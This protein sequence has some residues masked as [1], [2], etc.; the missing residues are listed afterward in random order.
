MGNLTGS[1][2]GIIKFLYL[3][4]NITRIIKFTKT[5]IT[6]CCGLTLFPKPFFMNTKSLF[7][8]IVFLTIIFTSLYS[9]AQTDSL[10][11]PL[12]EQLRNALDELNTNEIST[13]ILYEQVPEYFPL[14]FMDG[15]ILPDSLAMNKNSFVLGYG[16][17]YSAHIDQTGILPFR[18]LMTGV[19]NHL[20]P[21]RN[22][23]GFMYYRYNR[24]KDS[25]LQDSTIIV[26]QSRN[27]ILRGPNLLSPYVED[28]ILIF[29][30]MKN[31][32]YEKQ[33]T[34]YVE[35]DFL[36][37]NMNDLFEQAYIDFG[38]GNGF[39]AVR[40][41]S[42]FN[43]VYPSSGR[44]LITFKMLSGS[45]ALFAYS[46]IQIEDEPLRSRGY[47]GVETLTIPNVPQLEVFHWHPECGQAGYL[48][49]LILLDGFDPSD[50]Y[51]LDAIQEILD[52][53]LGSDLYPYDYD[54]FFINNPKNSYEDIFTQAEYFR[55]AIEWINEL[56]HAS[57][58]AE[59]NVVI[60]FSEG[61]L[62]GK[63]ALRTMEL[64][65]VD[66]ETKLFMTFD[67]INK[68][69]N[70]P[71]G[72][73]CFMDHIGHYRLFG[74]EIMDISLTVDFL[75]LDIDIGSFFNST[76]Y[77]PAAE[78]MLYYHI[79]NAN[80]VDDNWF[81]DSKYTYAH[82]L[83]NSHDVF[84]NEFE[85]LGNLNIPEVGIAN[86][87]IVDGSIEDY[88]Q[89]FGP[90]DNIIHTE[91]DLMDYI[92]G[93]ENIWTYI[94]D[95][96]GNQWNEVDIDMDIYAL[97]DGNGEV[98]D[99]TIDMELLTIGFSDRNIRKIRDAKPY[100]SA[101]GGTF[102]FDKITKGETIRDIDILHKE[103]CF[104]PT[105]SSLG[106]DNINNKLDPY[107]SGDL[108]IPSNVLPLTYFIDYTGSTDVVNPNVPADSLNFN[109]E[110]V[111]VGRNNRLLL[112]KYNQIIH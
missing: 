41:D 49:P 64:D 68:G 82:Y 86:G 20:D 63:I 5:D 18:D 72:I 17:I 39:Q 35:G 108:T 107:Y 76:L 33:Q 102:P 19:A 71:F 84:Y 34:Y 75:N 98:Y 96:F 44:Y 1:P 74:E 88:E 16:M 21:D 51:E 36:L 31:Q 62:T 29:S 110:H 4:F 105:I 42:E 100:D 48:K 32:S 25:V 58:S 65:E 26:D 77:S 55:A 9:V 10:E 99:G 54:I 12:E 59:E 87:T 83:D 11:L 13:G 66:H 101:P 80:W 38:D 79:N 112:L 50:G 40:S 45:K 2:I 109:E 23:L 14:K 111:Y 37:S 103:F 94:I 22:A 28:T 92:A 70:I 57:G 15:S 30:C 24:F 95:F 47:T 104:V 85:S 60:G 89:T 53:D 97:P 43:V 8:W 91:F 56:K 78:Q 81:L 27:K 52:Q 6:P 7:S 73:Q 106:M 61:A 67:G 46:Y 90:G 69:A 3:Y 93:T